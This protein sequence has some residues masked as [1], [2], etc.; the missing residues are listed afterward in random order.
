MLSPRLHGSDSDH[1]TNANVPLA[2][3]AAAAAVGDDDNDV[4]GSCVPIDIATRV[5]GRDW[6]IHSE[7]KWPY[8]DTTP[9]RVRYDIPIVVPVAVVVK[10]VPVV[11]VAA[12]FADCSYC[13]FDCLR[14]AVVT[15]ILV[16]SM[17]H[18]L[19]C[20]WT[21]WTTVAK[22]LV[23]DLESDRIE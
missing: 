10:V 7:T 1:S 22:I 14:L 23:L 15:V 6:N 2:P 9:L 20:C 13:T 12:V 3:A 5:P 18:F 17:N 4:V 21:T 16:E 11:A 19:R 8:C